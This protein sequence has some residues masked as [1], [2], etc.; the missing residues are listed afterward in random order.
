MKAQSREGTRIE[1]VERVGIIWRRIEAQGG[2]GVGGHGGLAS[3]VSL[4]YT[5]RMPWFSVSP[6]SCSH[7]RP[8]QD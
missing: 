8:R 7:W 3:I 5:P 1:R 6:T 4:P 2:E